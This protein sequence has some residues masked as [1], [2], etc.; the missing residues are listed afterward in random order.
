[1]VDITKKEVTFDFQIVA[2]N[3]HLLNQGKSP[4]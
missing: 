1:M 3:T 4:I 2:V